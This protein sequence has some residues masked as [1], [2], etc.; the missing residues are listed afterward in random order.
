MESYDY[1]DEKNNISGDE[2]SH[3][4]IEDLDTKSKHVAIGYNV[5]PKDKNDF[6]NMNFKQIIKRVIALTAFGI[7]L[8][9]S[10]YKS[11][12]VL[13]WCFEN[14]KYLR[15]RTE[16]YRFVHEMTNNVILAK[17]SKKWGSI[18]INNKNID[19]AI[20]YFDDL[21]AIVIEELKKWGNGNFD[22]SVEFHNY[23]WEQLNG[24]V[25]E[26]VSIDY[27]GVDIARFNLGK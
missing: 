23:V 21:D 20:E 18:D 27:V 6:R 24:N 15:S 2:M 22:N 8:F 7:V 3:D 10:F 16:A 1:E 4:N 25:G 12:N 11:I 13:G 9:T 26:A 14:N 19:K 17:D 5:D